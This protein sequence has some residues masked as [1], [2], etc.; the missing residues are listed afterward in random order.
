RPAARGRAPG[1]G[2][3]SCWRR[4]VRSWRKRYRAPGAPDIRFL[5][6]LC[7]EGLSRLPP[8]PQG[9]STAGCLLGPVQGAAGFGEDDAGQLGVLREQRGGVG[10]DRRGLAQQRVR[11]LLG[12]LRSEEH[13]SELQSR[14]NLVC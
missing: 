6:I 2:R 10:E 3:R 8:L 7:L 12:G 11:A 5:L 9:G 4:R 14:E 13:T 1:A